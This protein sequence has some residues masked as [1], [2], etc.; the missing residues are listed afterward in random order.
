MTRSRQIALA[1]LLP[2]VPAM[3]IA[4]GTAS[5]QP[6]QAEMEAKVPPVTQ[7][8][9]LATEPLPAQGGGQ[10][11][12]GAAITG[13]APGPGTPGR[14]TEGPPAPSPIDNSQHRQGTLL[15]PGEKADDMDAAAGA[16]GE[17]GERGEETEGSR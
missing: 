4:A 9:P 6:P 7:T 15:K 17:A 8:S 13:S 16:G 2:L 1:A 11:A 14:T 12:T 5:A 10:A 3:I